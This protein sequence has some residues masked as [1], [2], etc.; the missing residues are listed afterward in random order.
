MKK[1]IIL[2]L[3]FISTSIFA[4]TSE[5]PSGREYRRSSV[6]NANLV[7]TVFGNWGVI[8]Q[9]SSGGPRG[10]W[11]YDT[12][13]YIG[14]VS[15]MIGAEVEYYDSFAD[16]IKTFHSVVI[17]PIN[18]PSTGKEESNTGKRWCL[19]PV[20]GYFNEN[21]EKVAMSTDPTSWPP[22]W[23]DKM[24]ETDPGWT[25]KW[26]GLFGKGVFNADQESYYV[27][28]DNN[29]E[30]FNYSSNNDFG[31]SFKPNSTD[32]SRNGLGLVVK[33]RGLQ[34]QQ[35]LASD[36][37]FWLYEVTNTSTTDYSKVD[38]GMLCGTYVGVTGTDDSPGEY[39]DDYSFFDVENDITY[40]GDYGNSCARNPK[41]Q[42]NVG[43]VG[44]AFLESPGN[45][46]D[47]ID[48]DGDNKTEAQP[49]N[50]TLTFSAPV[51]TESDFDTVTYDRGD[52]LVTI[53]D[54]YERTLVTIDQDTQTVSTRGLTVIII[55][56][57]TKLIE[58]NTINDEY[59]VNPNVYDG[60][61]NDLDGLIDENY[62]LHYHQIRKDQTGKI[63]IDILNPIAYKDYINQIGL[64]DPL[65][66][67]SKFDGIDNDND[68]NPI[69]DDVG[70][71]GKDETGDPGENDGI[72]TYGEPNFD[73]T[74]VDE[75]DQIG[76]TSFNYFTPAGDY[77]EEN[78]E[79]LWEW[80]KPGYFDVPSTIV[81]NKPIAGEDGDFIYGSGYFPLP[82]GETRSF[83]LA[84][85]Y[86]NDLDDLFKNKATVQK[87]Y[88]ADYRFP[89]PPDKPT[90]TA[91]PGDGKVTLYW[92]RVAE[93]T[94]DPVTK[95]E[96]FEGYKIYKAT[97][98]DFNDVRTITNAD[99]VVTGYKWLAQYDLNNN[100]E[101]YF[102]PSSDLFQQ[103]E[104]YTF[105]LG[106]NTGLQHSYIDND[107]E[108]GRRYYYAVVA[109]DRG[110]ASEDIFPSENTKFISI[111]GDGTV[112]TDINSTVIRPSPKSA[113]FEENNNDKSLIQLSGPGTGSINY[114]IM[115][116]TKLTGHIY[117]V[118]FED[119][120]T[121][122]IDNDNDGLID[123]ED[124]NE[125]G[126]KTTTYSVFDITGVAD[127]V[128]LD[129][130]YIELPNQNIIKSTMNISL[131][132]NPDEYLSLTNFDIDS[133]RGKIKIKSTSELS[134]DDYILNYQYYPVFKSDKIKNS[135]YAKETKDSD[136]FDGVQ[137]V[138]SNNWSIGVNDTASYWNTTNRYNWTFSTGEVDLG[139][140]NIIS[141]VNYPAEYEIQ[142]GDGEM[143]ATEDYFQNAPY[144]F[145]KIK[146]DFRIFNLTDSTIVPFLLV[147]SSILNGGCDPDSV[148]SLEPNQFLETFFKKPDSSYQYTWT[149]SISN[150]QTD[151]DT[152]YEFG[153]GD[154]LHV[155]ITKPFRST[156]VF[157][158]TT[159]KPE[160]DQVAAENQI[161]DIQV[162]PNPYV[163]A[164][165]MEA[166]LPPTVTS[167]R[168][169][170]RIEFRKLPNDAKIYIFTTD[171]A[172][173]RTLNHSGSIHNGTL[174]WDLKTR[175]NLDIAFGVYFYIVESSVGKKSGKLAIIK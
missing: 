76:L 80:L 174:A 64:D 171:G 37:I 150:I 49:P 9:P 41:W 46:Y 113:G 155:A 36:V 87:I 13:G 35:F 160:I 104:G 133:A 21:N 135:P 39:D 116:E 77:P 162:V 165:N 91:V 66:D 98:P 122:G 6:H 23:P 89:Q 53:N 153:S 86:G 56:G 67:E 175:E 25:G 157:E 48:N 1:N 100:I 15:P 52:T 102:E 114:E 94:V 69:Y 85:V 111:Q 108:N 147:S 123:W 62:V 12:N 158:F 140:G 33:V 112:I 121:D 172:L 132:D 148:Y 95:E 31:V 134:E 57:E 117:R 169:E 161:S 71:D 127:T 145:P 14:D 74:D 50:S 10:S 164:N 92:D 26:N 101:G 20:A 28:N 27:M 65:I 142:F 42:G 54:K 118:F 137:L 107:V 93:K 55:A 24:N 115:D 139:G 78:D 109:Y 17:C 19:E 90:L 30:E 45:P 63:L 120:Q 149:I 143:Y 103:A 8:G 40:T 166:P 126:P 51:F 60:I 156:D 141:G 119:T 81:N 72:P 97:D 79:T 151:P 4:Q 131:S 173:I 58:G 75:S 2:I 110:D 88:N 61:D 105:N 83:S 96:D 138:F 16:S 146:S 68:W 84:L 170:R 22:Y 125:F 136:I 99:G 128:S 47:G 163:V 73:K 82:A 144:N 43:M 29:D 124:V 38:F 34:W 159:E 154:I 130:N 44:Y 168:G 167:G 5:Q 59:D 18:R 129:S 11:I 70:A 7:R 32:I 152:V 106:D 3:L